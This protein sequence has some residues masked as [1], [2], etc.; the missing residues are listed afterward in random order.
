M[1]KDQFISSIHSPVCYSSYITLIF[2]SIK[3]R[4]KIQPPSSCHSIAA[5]TQSCCGVW[6]FKILCHVKLNRTKEKTR[7]FSENVPWLLGV[8]MCGCVGLLTLYYHYHTDAEIFT[9]YSSLYFIFNQW[10]WSY[11]MCSTAQAT[12]VELHSAAFFSTT[13]KVFF[14]DITN[15]Q[16]KCVFTGQLTPQPSFLTRTL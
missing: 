12:E 15:Q 11:V 6:Y 14:C 7:G 2:Y 3:A 1:F 5:S 4:R 9:C 8:Q 13:S 10:M 16:S